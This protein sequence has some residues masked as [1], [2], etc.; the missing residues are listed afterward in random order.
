MHTRL[1]WEVYILQIRSAVA[2][3]GQT[4][5]Q[6]SCLGDIVAVTSAVARVRRL[7]FSLG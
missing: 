3:P 6:M 4:A 5:W 1:Y 7:H 2:P